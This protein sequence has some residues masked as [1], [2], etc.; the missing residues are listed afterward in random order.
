MASTTKESK[1]RAD[2]AKE[3]QREDSGQ[4]D[5]EQAPGWRPNKGERVT[6]VLSKRDVTE[7]KWGPYT[8]LTLTVSKAGDYRVNVDSDAEEGTLRPFNEG[9]PI[10][11]HAFHTVARNALNELR[12]K[13]GTELEVVYLGQKRIKG[14]PQGSTD[15]RDYYH[16]WTVRDTSVVLTDDDY[17]GKVQ[18][19]IGQTGEFNDEPPF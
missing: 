5:F 1:A 6:G 17:Y 4:L 12:P 15:P 13:M 7:N 11:W 2:A 19:D 16:A 3:E 8:I 14:R 10:A 9:D 18:G